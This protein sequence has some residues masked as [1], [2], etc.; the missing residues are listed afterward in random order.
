MWSHVQINGSNMFRNASL[1]S[2]IWL[3]FAQQ[4]LPQCALR[5]SCR[6][7]AVW[8]SGGDSDGATVNGRVTLLACLSQLREEGLQIG[9]I[10]ATVRKRQDS[11][12]AFLDRKLPKGTC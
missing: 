4:P 3:K 10:A 12:V 6:R 2:T 11:G 8:V 5:L 7:R 1:P 9:T